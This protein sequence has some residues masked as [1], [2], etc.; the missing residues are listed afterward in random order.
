MSQNAWSER[1]VLMN[2]SVDLFRSLGPR[3]QRIAYRM[4]GSPAEA[5]EVVQDAWLRWHDTDQAEIANAEAWLVSV[6]TRLAIDRLRALRTQRQHY[7]GTWL[8]EPFLSESP[9]T[10]DQVLEHFEDISVAF[11]T[12]LERLGPHARAAFLL[13]EICDTD[14]TA[15]AEALGKTE[16][17]CRQLVSRAKA[18]LRDV[19]RQRLVP[20]EMQR[21]LLGSFVDAT[22]SGD[23]SALQGL[24]ADDARFDSDGGG[25]VASF[26]RPF[27]GGRRIAQLYMASSLHFRDAMRFEVVALN[28]Q[29]GLIR[30]IR[31]EL[32]SAQTV[33]TDGHRIQHICAQRNP[34]KLRRIADGLR[35]AA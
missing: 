3:L 27:L 13:H 4:L 30:F 9:E 28:G 15:V 14:Y 33:E 21:R 32:E 5:E 16:E 25:V 18:R 7:V 11:L 8:A 6:T 12:V 10:P 1:L 22:L 20:Q 29:W 23:F 19:R 35:Q 17:A 26:G 34:E 2:A 24:L 31:G